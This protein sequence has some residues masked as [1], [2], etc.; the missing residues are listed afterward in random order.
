MVSS[1]QVATVLVI[2]GMCFVGS[3]WR[4]VKNLLNSTTDFIKQ[5]V[6]IFTGGALKL[7]AMIIIS[8]G[9]Y[10]NKRVRDANVSKARSS[11]A[12]KD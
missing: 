3:V 9:I 12:Q 5:L 8:E 6:N 2:K 1:L 7:M 11:R 4:D 10:M